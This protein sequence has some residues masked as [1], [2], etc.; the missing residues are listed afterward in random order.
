LVIESG[1]SWRSWIGPSSKPI[2]AFLPE[3]LEKKPEELRPLI[4]L[5]PTGRVAAARL[6]ISKDDN[7]LSRARGDDLAK[8]ALAAVLD[9][10]MAG[11]LALAERTPAHQ[12]VSSI[13]FER[14]A[15]D[16]GLLAWSADDW[17]KELNRSKTTIRKS[18]AWRHIQQKRAENKASRGSR[19]PGEKNSGEESL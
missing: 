10:G 15:K 5:T 11:V 7:Y 4:R 6:N 13:I 9:S 18:E 8:S 16:N 2:G 17:A 14:L 19:N 3:L 12:K 1:Y